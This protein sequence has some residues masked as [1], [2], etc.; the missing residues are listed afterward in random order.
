MAGCDLVPSAGRTQVEV[1]TPLGTM[2]IELYPTV[3][4]LTVANFLDYIRGGA[5]VGTIVHRA[6]TS[7]GGMPF[8]I[9]MGGYRTEG[10]TFESIDRADPI[11]NEPC[12]SNV[13]GTIAMARVGGSPNSA[14]SEWFVNLDDQ[15]V[16]LDDVDG[17]F[18][19]FGEV[20]EGMEVA[21]AIHDLPRPTQLLVPY[22]AVVPANQRALFR[23]APLT[24]L[25]EPGVVGCFDVDQSGVVMAADPQS[26]SDLEPEAATGA[27]FTIASAACLGVGTV[28]APAF[29]CAAP[30]RRVL[31]IDPVQGSLIPDGAAPF[32]FAET[33]LG[34][35]D[36][37]ASE[38]ALAT[39]LEIIDVAGKFV[40]TSYALPEPDASTLGAAALL[41]LAGLRR[42]SR[43]PRHRR[44]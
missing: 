26:P 14:T 38:A 17:G 44:R 30:G 19:V 27:P 23:E 15:N 25:P 5:Y 34:C 1:T 41:F 18:T 6:A 16:F 21:D 24:A 22:L 31:L 32:G 29:E 40:P 39:R 33:T 37:A 28:G 9:Q 3:A 4:P 42:V 20:I 36:L 11:P 7:T 13:R 12:I 10:T 2:R 8:V 43:R 35:A